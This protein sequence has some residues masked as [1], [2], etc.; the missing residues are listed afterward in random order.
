MLKN[1]CTGRRLAKQIIKMGI[2]KDSHWEGLLDVDSGGLKKMLRGDRKFS[3]SKV[4]IVLNEAKS[5]FDRFNLLNDE[6]EW[7]FFEEKGR[8]FDKDRK[9]V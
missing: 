3:D 8:D 7:F 4:V 5:M 9:S 6:I 2:V 1:S